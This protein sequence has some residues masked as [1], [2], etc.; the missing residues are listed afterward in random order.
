MTLGEEF[1]SQLKEIFQRKKVAILGVGNPLMGDDGVGSWIAEGLRGK[2]KVPVFVGEEVPENY[3][4]DILSQEPDYL[5]VIDA[6]DFGGEAGEARFVDMEEIVPRFLSSHGMSLNIMTSLLEGRGCKV[7][8][9]GIQPKN[10]A[11]GMEMSE[12]VK[13]SSENILSLIRSWLG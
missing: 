10:L 9:L 6:V 4:Y 8:L 1:L 12:E 2:V 7:I 5:L 3:L 13:R 11:F